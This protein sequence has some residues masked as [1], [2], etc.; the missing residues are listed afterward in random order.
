MRFLG[1]GNQSSMACVKD[2]SKPAVK[3][4][5]T[6]KNN[7]SK[8]SKNNM[9]TSDVRNMATSLLDKTLARK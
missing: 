7:D 1:N 3:V 4:F 6:F 2:N 5:E 9:S 8:R